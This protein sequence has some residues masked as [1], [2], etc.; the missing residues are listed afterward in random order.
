MAT[1]TS[2]PAAFTDNTTLPAATLNNLRGAF[3]VLQVVTASAG[4]GATNNTNTFSDTGLTATITPQ[5]NTSKILIIGSHNG[6]QKTAANAGNGVITGLLRGA[7]IL[8]YPSTGAGYTGTA[9][10]NTVSDSFFYLDSPAS[11]SALTYKTQFANIINNA[12]VLVQASNG[13][14]FA[15]SYITLMEISA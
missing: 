7:T 3:R 2:L 10:L 11:T 8:T 9:L 4:T 15:T 1:P 13:A 6:L 14:G 12:G 5:S